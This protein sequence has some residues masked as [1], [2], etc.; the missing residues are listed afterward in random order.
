M[1]KI[2]LFA[3]SAAILLS[4]CSKEMK[5]PLLE[6]STLP[7]GAPA[8]DKIKSE[9]YKPAF[10]YALK[11][12]RTEIDAIINNPEKPTFE[13]TIEAMERSGKDLARISGLFFNIK[14]ANAD[15]ILD[16]TAEEITPALTEFSLYVSMNEK[17]FERVKAVYAMKD[18]LQLNQEQKKLLENT[19]KSFSRNGANLDPEKKAEYGKIAEKLSLDQLQFSKNTLSGTNSYTLNITDSNDLKGLPQYVVD[20][21]AAEAAERGVEG[22]VYTLQA[23]SYSPFMQFAENRELRKQM[24]MAANTICTSGEFDNREYVRDIV[25]LRLKTAELLGYATYADYSLEENMAK[26]SATVNAFLDN[27]VEQTMPF[28]KADVKL[29]ADF[30][31]EKGLKGQMMPW[32]FSYYSELY[33]HE[34]F[35]LNDELLKPY[36]KLENVQNAVFGLANRLYGITITENKEIPAYNPDVK[37]FEVKDENG[38][39]LALLYIDYFPRANKQ[40]G[41]WMT[42]FR[43]TSVEN[44]VEQRPL[45]NLVLNFTKPSGDTPSLLTFYEVTTLLHEFGHSLHG[46]LAKGTYGSLTGTNVARDFVELPSQIMEN[47][48]SE[49]EFLASF[50][51]H[52]QTG[53]VIPS[54]YI[55]R[56]RESRNFLSGYSQMRQLSFGV[57]DMAWHSIT[58]PYEGDILAFESKA[59]ERT[60]V[61]PAIEGTSMAVRFGHIFAGG[62]AA[63]YYSYKWAEV[64][65]ADAFSL[66]KEKGIFNREVASSFRNNIL[67]MGGKEDADVIYRN[68]RGRDP[69]PEAL[70]V[71]LGLVKK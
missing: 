43:G 10:E 57:Q 16:K 71:K 21:G 22:W 11:E 6:E 15:D 46:M 68:F 56:I 30:A 29:V 70:M 42:E 25:N 61:L 24:W 60:N 39:F 54:E 66:F 59:I 9:H 58:K 5:N 26:S 37:V 67:S 1:K 69:Q 27:L 44:G 13:N 12:A 63:G 40:S 19:Y 53:E 32:D 28:A 52:Y 62:Y 65:E 17:L 7:Y 23:P 18:S 64:L 51:K 48:A 31:K 2:L 49:P 20:M 34:K 41:A 55:D 4:S 50:A 36:F 45:I 8:F 14:E 47:W 3:A 38:A 33:K 35:N